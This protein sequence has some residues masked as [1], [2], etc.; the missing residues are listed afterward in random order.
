MVEYL[1]NYDINK[2]L[3]EKL[4]SLAN[5]IDKTDIFTFDSVQGM[6]REVIICD[7]TITD[8]VGFLKDPGRLMVALSRC[9]SMLIIIGNIPQVEKRMDGMAYKNSKIAQLFDYVKSNNFRVCVVGELEK[10]WQA[11]FDTAD[12]LGDRRIAFVRNENVAAN[13]AFTQAPVKTYVLGNM[14]KDGE[15][16][17]QYQEERAQI[18]RSGDT[19]MADNTPVEATQWDTAMADDTP[20]EA[21]QWDMAIADDTPVEATTWD[22]AMAED[23]PVEA[24]TWDMAMGGDSGDGGVKVNKDSDGNGW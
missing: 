13:V 9:R 17:K 8:K 15:A 7:L 1:A 10:E 11:Q 24:T 20:V 12:D 4:R 2:T 3:K 23:T 14:N 6:Q 16:D 22:M 5:E 21:T 19:E 18:P